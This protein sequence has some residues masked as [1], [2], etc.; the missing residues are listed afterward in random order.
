MNRKVRLQTRILYQSLLIN[1]VTV[2]VFVGGT[3]IHLRYGFKRTV[4][5][6]LELL[7][8]EILESLSQQSA[9]LGQQ[10]LPVLLTLF[11]EQNPVR[12]LRLETVT[13]QALFDNPRYT[14]LIAD[15]LDER[16]EE[17]EKGKPAERFQTL[18]S[19]GRTL[20][21][22][23]YEN[24]AFRIYMAADLAQVDES[25]WQILIAFLVMLPVTVLASIIAS[26]VLARRVTDPLDSLARQAKQ[27]DASG[28]NRAISI[29]DATVEVEALVAI[30]N[31]MMDRLNR[32]FLQARRFSADASHEL[33]TP[34]TVMH[35]ILAQKVDAAAEGGLSREELDQ[36]MGE[37][38][39]MRKIVEALV[40]LA[41]ADEQSL[42]QI[43]HTVRLG[44]I[45]SDLVEDAS[46]MGEAYGVTARLSGTGQGWLSGDERLIRLALYNLL[47]NAVE[48]AN[49]GS[50]VELDCQINQGWVELQVRNRGRAISEKDRERIFDRFFC[51]N[52]AAVEGTRRGLGLGLNLAMEVARAHGGTV[53]LLRSDGELTV[54]L[55]KLPL[56][57]ST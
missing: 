11:D 2:V 35:G 34:L 33:K 19:E 29:R 28:L 41:K 36:L 56:A 16:D 39:R 52:G 44:P 46:A 45:L 30:L 7:G 24:R 49:P 22:A 57:V 17:L 48:N 50:S 15:Y 40:V 18:W 1:L 9:S 5:A 6:Q 53:Q 4:D 25:L 55:L 51:G 47:K 38:N 20:R 43:S 37:T 27:T 14:Q 26:S 54:F 32:S 10:E 31:D 23:R 8:P 21:V 13:N 12:I 3:L 42:L